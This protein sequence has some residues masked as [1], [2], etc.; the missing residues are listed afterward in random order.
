MLMLLPLGITITT[1]E[2]SKVHVVRADTASVRRSSPRYQT[3]NLHHHPMYMCGPL[4]LTYLIDDVCWNFLP[5][6]TA[7]HATLHNLL[8]KPIPPSTPVPKLCSLINI[9]ATTVDRSSLS[10]N[11]KITL[12]S[13]IYCRRTISYITPF[14]TLLGG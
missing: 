3:F 14:S 5:L 13:T 2:R 11:I 4:I 1:L 6:H 9:N 10:H 8:I 12:Q 7:H